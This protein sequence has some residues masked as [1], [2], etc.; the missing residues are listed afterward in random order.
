[1]SVMSVSAPVTRRRSF[2]RAVLES[3]G[4]V[5]AGL[6]TI[7]L[8]SWLIGIM[9]GERDQA[10]KLATLALPALAAGA[11]SV[12]SPCSFP[13]MLGYFSVTFQQQ[14]KRIGLIT[15]AFLLGV[16]TTMSVLGA[17]FTALGSLAIDYQ[18]QMARIGGLLIIAFGIMTLL[19]KG[20]SGLGL[21]RSGGAGAGAAYVFGLMFALGWT[22]CVGPILG[23]IL[24]M[25]LADGASTSGAFSLISGAALAQ[26]YV[27]GMG[28]PI[29]ILVTALVRG[30]SGRDIG[31]LIQGR[32]VGLHL[33]GRRLA[34]NV[35]SLI[36]GLLLVGLGILLFTGAMT[37]L[38]QELGSSWLAQ[39]V[40]RI[41]EHL[42]V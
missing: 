20:F 29:L 9:L 35:M 34:I 26:V 1:M 23:S 37:R 31:K 39:W 28:L 25:L 6:V 7:V 33:G 12:L 22:A 16:G 17:S 13:I 38:T 14:P 41:E 24:T 2:W 36:S 21:T 8:V 32:E 40:V 10:A 11:L 42:P 30:V 4:I 18:E 27:L 15:L 3:L 5:V 19:G